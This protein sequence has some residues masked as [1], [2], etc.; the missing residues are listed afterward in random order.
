M[1]INPSLLILV[2]SC[3]ALTTAKT[4]LVET[5]PETTYMELEPLYGESLSIG[6]PNPEDRK[7][8]MSYDINGRMPDATNADDAF[9]ASAEAVPA[10]AAPAPAP[11]A[12]ADSSPN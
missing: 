11:A 12:P 6:D 10:A 1:K 2:L 9:E 4:F 3:A 8:S 7:K 5:K